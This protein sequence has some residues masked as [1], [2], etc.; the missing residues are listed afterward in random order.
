MSAGTMMEGTHLALR[1]WFVAMWFMSSQKGRDQR[2][3]GYSYKT[4]GY[5]L[6]RIRCAI[7]RLKCLQRPFC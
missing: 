1:E 5:V 4:A 7:A 2:Q 6:V 3:A